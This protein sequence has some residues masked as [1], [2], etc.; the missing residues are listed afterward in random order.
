[1][2]L[3]VFLL[4]LSITILLICIFLRLGVPEHTQET[5]AKAEVVTTRYLI[6]DKGVE[7]MAGQSVSPFKIKTIAC[8]LVT[9]KMYEA[10]LVDQYFFPN[11]F[12]RWVVDIADHGF[13][14]KPTSTYLIVELIGSGAF[15]HWV[16]EVA[17]YLPLFLLLKKEIPLLKL[18]FPVT[19][20]TPRRT[21]KTLFCSFFGIASTDV[22]YELPPTPKQCIFVSPIAALNNK[23]Y[24]TMFNLQISHFFREIQHRSSTAELCYDFVILPRQTKENFGDKHSTLTQIIDFLK[25]H[26]K[27][28]FV[29][30]TDEITDL[31]EQIYA[32][33]RT[34]HVIVTDGS[35]FL[36]NGLLCRE[37]VISVVTG[38]VT[39]VQCELYPKMKCIR[40]HITEHNAN[41]YRYFENESD[42][43]FTFLLQT[44][45]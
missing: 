3:I 26:N 43:I 39:P 10:H 45:A 40:D 27:K 8:D 18:A 28:I 30:N 35:A 25:N 44:N 23:D 32:L 38:I 29:L 34:K 20:Y 19:Q 36:V 21:Y 5:A 12:D 16:F 42:W 17:I 6:F 24:V 1:M 9:Y 13:E 4:L 22:V 33:S 14:E 31:K 15:A 41:E 37:K 7:D 2:M 11:T